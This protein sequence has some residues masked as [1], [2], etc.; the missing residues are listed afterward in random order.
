MMSLY[1]RSL[2]REYELLS[3]EIKRTVELFP[4]DKDQGF[5]A[6]SG[7]VAFKHYH[8]LREKRLNLEVEQ[9]LYFLEETQPTK[10]NSIT[11]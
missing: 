11:S 10:I 3:S 6:T 5:G 9:S 4:Q 8:E 1:V 2:A 7:H